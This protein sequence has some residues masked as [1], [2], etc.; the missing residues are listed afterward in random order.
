MPFAVPAN[1]RCCY[2][3]ADFLSKPITPDALKE[4]LE[5]W[6][7]PDRDAAEFLGDESQSVINYDL[8]SHKSSSISTMMSTNKDGA[9]LSA[10]SRL[11]A[12]D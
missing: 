5:K 2:L 9:A 1:F 8:I 7:L 4:L 11:S 3:Y 10:A 6:I 12:A